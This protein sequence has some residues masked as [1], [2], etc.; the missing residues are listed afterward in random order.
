MDAIFGHSL[1]ARV[2]TG[3]AGVPSNVSEV[4]CIGSFRESMFTFYRASS[5]YKGR[6]SEGDRFTSKFSRRFSWVVK[7]V[8]EH[9]PRCIESRRSRNKRIGSV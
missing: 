5:V 7:S 6:F 4:V 2:S 3:G 1:G 9:H 8:S